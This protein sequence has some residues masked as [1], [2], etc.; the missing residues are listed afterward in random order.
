MMSQARFTMERLP[1]RLS[2]MAEGV[3]SAKAGTYKN[4]M[5]YEPRSALVRHAWEACVDKRFSEKVL[6]ASVA[7]LAQAAQRPKLLQALPM[8][9]NRL[10][11]GSSP[12]DWLAAT[13]LD[14]EAI[15][16]INATIGVGLPHPGKKSGLHAYALRPQDFPAL[17]F[18]SF[19]AARLATPYEGGGPHRKVRDQFWYAPELAVIIMRCLPPKLDLLTVEHVLRQILEAPVGNTLTQGTA[20]IPTDI[21][22]PGAI[23]TPD[24]RDYLRGDVMGMVDF[25]PDDDEKA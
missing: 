4:V 16:A 6:L 3:A 9:W 5:Y 2:R 7:S 19:I 12:A 14:A 17:L 23:G 18:L 22:P 13:R 15:D 10:D 20:G 8:A 21:F 24:I 11:D 25:E 1:G